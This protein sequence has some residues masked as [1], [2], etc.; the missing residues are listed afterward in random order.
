MQ[1]SVTLENFRPVEVI[2]Q[3]SHPQDRLNEHNVHECSPYHNLYV[4]YID[5]GA[6]QP[7]AKSYPNSAT[8]Y[9]R[10]RQQNSMR[11]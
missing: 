1:D 8:D 5:P 10:T 6:L 4:P 11:E 7:L 9:L 3:A 2:Y